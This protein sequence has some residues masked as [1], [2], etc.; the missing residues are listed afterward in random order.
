MKVC[1]RILPA[2]LR[3][4]VA[5]ALLAAATSA[6]AA[7]T[8]T[9][10]VPDAR[11]AAYQQAI[12]SVQRDPAQA[13]PEAMQKLL[14]L[15]MDVGQ[16][17][18]AAV[19]IKSYLAQHRDPSPALLL[20]AAQVAEWAGDLR[21]AVGRYKQVLKFAPNAPSTPDSTLRLLRL[22]VDDLGANDDAYRLMTDLGDA[23]RATVAL[24]RYD[25]WYLE[26]AKA[27]KDNA[28]LARRLVMIFAEQMPLELERMAYWG[29]LDGLMK[30]L[31]SSRVDQSAL[32]DCRRLA[33]GLIR[34]N[35]AWSK[36]FAFL[37]ANLGYATS[38][39]GKDVVTREREFDA[40][41][42]AANTYVDAA[43]TV[44][45]VR[46]IE[47]A[48]GGNWEGINEALLGQNTRAK[49]AVFAY[50]F[51][52]LDNAQRDALLAANSQSPN[53]DA[54]WWLPRLA[55]REQFAQI[56]AT[57][58]AYFRRSAVVGRI[59]LLGDST[60]AAYY[61]ALAPALQGVPNADALA[62]VAM[63]S[64]DDLQG[65]WQRI[66]QDSWNMDS[67]DEIP[68]TMMDRVW[69]RFRSF[70]RAEGRLTDDKV[71]RALVRFGSEVL[72]RSPQFLFDNNL[73]LARSYALAAWRYSSGDSMDKSKVSAF[74]H[75]LDWIPY[76][77]KDR[78]YVFGAA[79][80]EFR[81]WTDNLRNLQRNGK[82][83]VEGTTRELAAAKQ[84]RDEAAKK[85]NA[86][87]QDHDR[88]I[89]ELTKKLEGLQSDLA[90]ADGAI[91][92][93][94]PMEELF[95]QVKDPKIGDLAKAPDEFCRNLGKLVVA[96]REK[97]LPAYLEAARLLYTMVRDY[98]TKKLPYYRPTLVVLLKNRFDAFDTLDFQCEVVAD[99]LTRV[100]PESGNN[101]LVEVLNL[102]EENRPN[103]G[104]HR[105]QQ[106]KLN[107]VLA[108]GMRDLLARKQYSPVV[109]KWFL[110]TRQG[111][112][113]RENERDQDVMETLIKQPDLMAKY[114]DRVL[115]MMQWLR[116]D[117]TKLAEKYPLANAFDET[118][119]ADCRRRRYV[120]HYYY[121][122][123]GHDDRGVIIKAAAEVFPTY[124]RLPFGYDGGPVGYGYQPHFWDMEWNTF[125][126]SPSAVRD[127]MLT[128]LESYGGK[129]RFD[130]YANGG[131][132]LSTNSLVNTVDRKR[133]FD[134]MSAWVSA[135]ASEPVKPWSGCVSPAIRP[136]N[137]NNFK[138]TLES[139]EIDVL[140]RL[141]QLNAD[142]YWG[143][144]DDFN[145]AFQ[146][147]L[148]TAKRGNE[149]F[150]LAPHLW[151]LA[152][153]AQNNNEAIRTHLVG[154]ANGLAD[155]GQTELAVCYASCGLEILGAVLKEDQRNALLA[156]KA[157]ALKGVLASVAIDHADPRFPIFQAQ[158]DYQM[159]KIDDAWQTYMTQRKLFVDSF[160]ELDPSFSIWVITKLTDVG[161]YADAEANAKLMIQWV[162]QSP[163]SFDTADRARLMLAYANISFS[164]Q[165]YPRARAICEQ[166]ASSKEFEGTQ[167]QYDADMKIAEI[168][169]ITKHYDKAILR[170]E[171][172]LRKR[173]NY[174][175]AEA[176][177]Q[178]ALV[179]FDQEEYPEARTCIEKALTVAP[180]HANARILGGKINLRMKQYPEATRVIVGLSASQQTI[181][182]GKPLTV[183]LE[184]RNLAVVGQN[185]TIEIRAWTDSG[186][187]EVFALLP[188]G[189]SKT[190]FEGQIPTALATVHKG[191]KTLQVLGGDMVHYDFS[192]AFKRANKIAGEAPVGIRVLSDAELYVSSGKILSKEEDEQRQ[193]EQM[194]RVRMQ[195]D[196]TVERTVALSTL[197]AGDEI[198][199][200]NRINV[201]VVDPGASVTTNRNKV[202]VKAEVSSGDRID[203]VDLLE[204]AAYTGVF[205]GFIPTASA[206]AT[207]F[208]LDSEEGKDPNFAITGAEYP[209]WV[210][211]PDN[212]RPKWFNVDLNNS[213]QLG[214]MKILANVPGRHLR[215]FIVQVSPNGE[216]F[217]L[218]G[219]WPDNLKGG[220]S[221]CQLEVARYG[222]NPH[223]P[224]SLREF[225]EF[226]DVGYAASE[227]EK[228]TVPRLAFDV[229]WDRN[230]DGLADRMQLQ[231]DGP[232]GWFVGHLQ[233]TFY[234][235]ARQKRMF[236]V[237]G[238][239]PKHPP[240]NCILAVDGVS[241]SKIGTS[242][243]S[244]SLARGMHRLDVYFAA[245][246][247]NGMRCWVE[248]DT[249]GRTPFVMCTPE[250]FAMPTNI[251]LRERTEAA[252]AISFQ[253]AVITNTPD[254]GTFT[255]AFPSNTLARVVR[256]WLL[257]FET[258]APAIQK[259]QLT[260][261]DGRRILP[262]AQDV[263]KL[264]END[265]L[266][267]VPGDRITITY[268]NLHPLTKERQ[269]LESFM[270]VTFHNAKL[271]ACFIESDV[272]ESG[273]RHPR[274]IPM[275][276]F[277]PGDTVNVFIDDP[278]CDTTDA[279]DVVPFRVRVGK[280]GKPITIQALETEPH[281]GVFLG[282][283]FPVAGTPQRP[284][285]VHLEP[286]EDLL[287]TYLD[288]ENTDPGIP[289]ERNCTVEQA[290]DGLPDLRVGSAVSRLLSEDELSAVQT[291]PDASKRTEEV[292]P[293]TRTISLDVPEEGATNAAS[294]VLLG[295]PQIVQLVHPAI[296]LSPLSR[297]TIYVQTA[298][299]RK[300][301]SQPSKGA[302]D[303]TV[304]GTLRI[305]SAPGDRPGIGAPPGYREV[306]AGYREPS[307]SGSSSEMSA[308][309]DGIFTFVVPTRLGAVPA[310]S[311]VD[312]KPLARVG[313]GRDRVANSE[314]DVATT[315]AICGGDVIYIG[316]SYQDAQGSNRWMTASSVVAGDSFFDVMDRRYREAVTNLHVGESVYLRVIDPAL[317]RPGEKKDA[318]VQVTTS[319]GQKQTVTL[320]ETVDHAGAYKGNAQLV[321]AG[322]TTSTNLLGAVC[323]NYGDTV[324]LSYRSPATSQTL[325]RVVQVFKG[326]DGAGV[327]FTKR[328]K[329]PSIAVQTQF[330]LAEAYFEMAKK[331]RDLQQE[332]S[333]RR[334]IGQ[335]KKLL[336]EAI[337]DYPTTEARAQADYLLANL[338]IE[339]ASQ[340]QD[341]AQKTRYYLEAV[342]R[343]TEIV[344]NSPDSPYAPKAQFRKAFTYEKMGR[345]DDACEEYVKLSYRYP[346]NELVA[347]TIARLGNYFLT[348]GQG[349]E[350]EGKAQTDLVKKE[351]FRLQA[352]DMFKTAAQVFG[353]LGARFPD[354]QLAA[355]TAVISAQCWLR[356]EDFDQAI[357]I[358]NQ[359]I[360]A[361]KGSSE[362]MA[363][364][365]YWCGDA[366]LR[367]KDNV[368]AYRQMK[369]L[370]W[371]FP[372]SKWAK[373]ARGRLSEPG[374]ADV[375]ESESAAE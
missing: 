305:E 225:K 299:G 328:F 368:N 151:G 271:S 125:A 238:P 16:P 155:S 190:K 101:L 41:A 174:V 20:Q 306:S 246:R 229:N 3:G 22:L 12:E 109:F 74:F 53:W 210:A 224:A 371:D 146:T 318:L 233:G 44:D 354:H 251:P 252:Q 126:N 122:L 291:G 171:N 266:E 191:D 4:A 108:K 261:A 55:S 156:I 98:E 310:K 73:S 1:E 60:N 50:A 250:M 179:K 350:A 81:Q 29:A 270:R 263:V 255:I 322:D 307:G 165:E 268:E 337:R 17:Q 279:C 111:N 340:V 373:Y 114:D 202:H 6:T 226:L 135:R 64:S 62:I 338:A 214:T 161:N 167:A 357:A 147:H 317:K 170:L 63:G 84:A 200:G 335:G 119:A 217:A 242:E 212:R 218:V 45:T 256:L 293:V 164:R 366:Y 133:Y 343:F 127:A 219:A 213:C 326:A 323:V 150:A 77:D 143:D 112:G 21:T 327:A 142:W 319:S 234:Q 259:I 285:E 187:D 369:K 113:W 158:A 5:L 249:K 309:D 100:T 260:A 92:Q 184:D 257:D 90:K 24:K 34:G 231:W 82:G 281:S 287:I 235:T 344:A 49:S 227:C 25:G 278:D 91:N 204:T 283:I 351:R 47:R 124:E 23:A 359:V 296:A 65:C 232:R 59:P 312:V 182:P 360:A 181:V 140:L 175:Q 80:D 276:R 198:K 253:P 118:F 332:E 320:S 186:D 314:M 76:T 208:S 273:T 10:N 144:V 129:T 67:F 375:E 334:E 297:A 209:P 88:R 154:W 203:R 315:L 236:R 348:K 294:A 48:F 93:V 269:F 72:A 54:S 178:L 304:P 325:T 173:D 277:K 222:D 201:R 228:I 275:R 172:L 145:N 192:E 303:L 367:R 18:A 176:N 104:A 136:P 189:D 329:D 99:Q 240:Q 121:D 105:E 37:T 128:K 153:S 247:Q 14:A 245:P 243:V 33:G 196:A 31:A 183:T 267:I 254:N 282:K 364:A 356:A 336:E 230:L 333:A 106:L 355:K 120:E 130:C 188:F 301:S 289:W 52:K 86:N 223:A 274:Y 131:I 292:V 7:T 239:D 302:F 370:T 265:Q 248:S 87:L 374:L 195:N 35:E 75:V 330:T 115:Q 107:A 132:R 69:P 159:G 13:S 36:R 152:R 83:M 8:T 331:H 313:D 205:E 342:S 311:Q 58:A 237:A 157:K 40:V 56:V 220:R 117:F 39:G 177:Y 79:S 169:R 85:P 89:A 27:R 262:T 137:V 138:L 123:G 199:P 193:L 94:T 286:N 324:T 284:S 11:V 365:M 38:A 19:I 349:I 32:A 15:S 241:G 42:A 162:E 347:E 321:Y 180:A 308:L 68:R 139:D 221:S 295:C 363:E 280:T 43:P 362:L 46:D 345:I 141:F 290:S 300:L 28:A 258:D 51:G 78:A 211:L 352:I 30:E 96:V 2:T 71:E 244:Q 116:T 26:Q 272:D 197:R 97:N 341:A 110:A 148:L 206:P 185:A 194:I 353:R 103:E 361:K 358:F 372:D 95:R 134:Q 9:T 264:R 207:A 149:L 160:R 215:K 163:Q 102:T 70:S 298:A 66:V 316:Y 168:D 346:D 339:Y 57:N 166:V 216:D 288:V 61:K